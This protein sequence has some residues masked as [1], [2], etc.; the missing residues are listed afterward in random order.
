MPAFPPHLPA[1]A[2]QARTE[3]LIRQANQQ[4]A[5]RNLPTRH[6]GVHPGRTPSA[7]PSGSPSS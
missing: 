4:R 2:A 5:R 6:R 3:E 7:R 1:A